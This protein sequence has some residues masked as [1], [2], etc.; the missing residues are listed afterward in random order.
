[1]ATRT[2]SAA[3]AHAIPKGLRVGSWA[4]TSTYS[5]AAGQSISVGDVI[6]MIRVPAN[7][8]VVFV[9]LRSTYAQ[10]VV[11]VGDGLS[12]ARYIGAASTS[13][14]HAISNFT[15]A[16]PQAGAAYTYSTEDTIDIAVS[17][18]SITTV[19]GA[20][21]LTAILTMDPANYS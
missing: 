5:V 9:G 6:Q 16:F 2:A 18:V 11:T 3:Q 1:M 20:F 17:L 8:S 19:L 7:A 13:A 10:A 14:A 15:S 12:D 4:V 21:Y